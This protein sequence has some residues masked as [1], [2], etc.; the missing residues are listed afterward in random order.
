LTQ[1]NLQ[2]SQAVKVLNDRLRHV[3][4]LNNDIADWLQVGSDVSAAAM[5]Y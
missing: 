3:N 4:K 1:A 5:G 2:P